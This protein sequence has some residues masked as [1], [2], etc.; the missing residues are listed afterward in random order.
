MATPITEP[1]LGENNLNNDVTEEPDKLNGAKDIP[2]KIKATTLL[3]TSCLC[4]NTS[5]VCTCIHLNGKF[6]QAQIKNVLDLIKV[7]LCKAGPSTSNYNSIKRRKLPSSESSD[8]RLTVAESKKVCKALDSDDLDSDDCDDMD[9]GNDYPI[10]KISD[11][12]K[13]N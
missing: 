1:L 9:N 13:V 8:E 12:L 6:N 10:I 2:P 4:L 7:P 3:N 11:L 5:G